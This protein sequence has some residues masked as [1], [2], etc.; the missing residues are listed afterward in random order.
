MRPLVLTAMPIYV[1]HI[2]HILGLATLFL[3]F[4]AMQSAGEIKPGMK[5]HG[6][7][8]VIMLISGFGMLAKLGI[9]AAM[10]KWV[11]IKIAMW[12][13]L[14]ALPTLAKRKI[15]PFN[16]LVLVAILITGVN[17]WLGYLKPVW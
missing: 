11:I 16:L 3:G 5:W 4:G 17:A 15:I 13:V 7:G 8:L 10:P 12:L 2:L 1:Y 14:G 9:F 6:I